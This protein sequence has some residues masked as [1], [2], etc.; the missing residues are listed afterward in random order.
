MTCA[1]I[2]E[3]SM[4]ARNRV[5]IGL[6]YRSEYYLLQCLPAL[7]EWNVEKAFAIAFDYVFQYENRF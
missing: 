6:S 2:L 3:Q 5:R 7:E 4:G 1:G